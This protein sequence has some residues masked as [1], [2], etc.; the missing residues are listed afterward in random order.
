[1]R[2]NKWKKTVNEKRKQIVN[3]NECKKAEKK[4]DK[5]MKKN[6]RI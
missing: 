2:I 5:W 6:E 4:K 1:M 3:E